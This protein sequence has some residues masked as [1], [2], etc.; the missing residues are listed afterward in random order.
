MLETVKLAHGGGGTLTSD[1]IR[2]E[3]LAR[4]GKGPLEGLPDAA[5]LVNSTGNLVFSTDSFVVHPLLFP[6]GTIGNLAVHGTVNDLAVAGGTPLWLSLSLI[7][8]EGLPFET[9]RTVLDSVKEAAVR[10]GVNVVTGDTKVV[11]RGQCDGMYINTAGIGR[12]MPHFHLSTKR[13]APGDAVMTSG[14][15]GDHGM[16]VLAAREGINIR[17]GPHSDSAPVHHLVKAAHDFADAVKFMRDPTRGGTAAVLN[18]IVED[19]DVGIEL[20]EQALPISPSTNTVAE[21][22]GMDILN[23][24]SEG[25]LLLICSPDAADGILDKWHGLD[26]GKEAAVIGTVTGDKARVVLRTMTGG[27]RLVDVPQGELLPRIC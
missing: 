9:L 15:L 10:C 3:I 25:R 21:M 6:G 5:T 20:Q 27:R 1:F 24:A 4:F 17:N 12:C 7:L 13:L 16:A 22:L 2:D 8:E 26:H 19:S 18:E 11:A 14:P 23:V